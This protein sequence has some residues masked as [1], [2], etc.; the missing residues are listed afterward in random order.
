MASA[1]RVEAA[2]RSTGKELVVLTFSVQ[3]E[4]WI[5]SELSISL[6]SSRTTCD[7]PSRDEPHP[8]KKYWECLHGQ[9]K[10]S[11]FTVVFIYQEVNLSLDRVLHI[12]RAI[13]APFKLGMTHGRNRHLAKAESMD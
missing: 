3:P 5:Q 6:D 10:S 9:G 13:Q 12:L 1:A 8:Q 4:R 7:A 2:A 11:S